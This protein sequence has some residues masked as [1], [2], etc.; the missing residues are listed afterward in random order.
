MMPARSLPFA[1]RLAAALPLALAAA[2]AL[3]ASPA[4]ALV[5]SN[6]VVFETQ[7]QSMWAPGDAFIFEFNKFLGASWNKSGSAKVGCI[8]PGKAFCVGASAGGSTNGRIGVDFGFSFDAGSVNAHLP[9]QAGFSFPSADQLVANETF[10]LSTFANLA[11]GANFTTNFPEFRLFADLVFDVFARISGSG[12][13]RAFGVGPCGSLGSSTIMNV[14]IKQELVGV[15][16]DGDGKLGI[17][18]GLPPPANLLFSREED[19]G[20]EFEGPDLSDPDDDQNNNN[21][22][23]NNNQNGDQKK[24]SQGFDLSFL[25]GEVFVPD[26]ETTGTPQG[27]VLKSSGEDDIFKLNVDIDQLVTTA[28]GVPPLGGSVGFAGFSFSYDILDITTGPIL[29]LTQE[30]TLTPKV[31]VDLA[32][33][34]PVTQ[35]TR[36]LDLE[37]DPSTF[38]NNVSG[39]SCQDSA[40]V[41]AG[42][43][44]DAVFAGLQASGV[45]CTGVAK[46]NFGFFTLEIPVNFP[47][48]PTGFTFVETTTEHSSLTLTAGQSVDLLFEGV[49]IEVDPTYR[50][51][52]DFTNKTGLRIDPFFTV[53]VLEFTASLPFSL[54]SKSVGPLFKET[55]R[56]NGVS[57]PSLFNKTFD[58]QGFDPY[59][60]DAVA[61]GTLA[62]GDGGGIPDQNGLPPGPQQDKIIF[63]DE[64]LTFG[65]EGNPVPGWL[66]SGGGTAEIVFDPFSDGNLMVSLTTGSPVVLSREVTTPEEEFSL[67]FDFIWQ[68][69]EGLLNFF[70]QDPADDADQRSLG[71][72]AAADFETGERFHFRRRYDD[73]SLLGLEDW[74]LVFLL[75]SENTSNI[76]LD[77]VRLAQVPLP[78]TWLLVLVGLAGLARTRA[79]P[80]PR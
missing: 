8:D 55:L 12:C 49:P 29:A 58:L 24:K 20:L 52:A 38:P 76:L 17:L 32:F 9:Y 6:D 34:E 75:D 3:A 47:T 2:F 62:N 44:P 56:A 14:D 78:A 43:N 31:L 61:I 13:S 68:T 74:L 54:G 50:I 66:V 15:N 73:P 57:L 10:T 46:I 48:T 37:L 36:S 45:A 63:L 19:L 18:R 77:N 21:N 80:R 7:N 65:D 22:N 35:R 71:S 27:G 1:R 16:R 11:P 28:L 72:L 59:A 53:T 51:D 30:F 60:G 42:G 23:N 79:A 41:P 69:T 70:L 5:V 64:F 39:V 25:S 4:R 26:I 33:A 40:P 67:S